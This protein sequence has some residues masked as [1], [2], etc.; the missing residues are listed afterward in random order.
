[1]TEY[2]ISLNELPAALLASSAEVASR[3]HH[4][5]RRTADRCRSHVIGVTNERIKDTTGVF[6]ASYEIDEA[7]NEI[8]LF[9][10]APHAEFVEE[11]TRPRSK[12][13]PLLPILLWLS[14]KQNAAATIA[15]TP[16]LKGVPASVKNSKRWD[17]KDQESFSTIGK[18][19]RA[20]ARASALE[21][22]RQHAVAI[23]RSIKEK[24]TKPHRIMASSQATFEAILTEELGGLD[25]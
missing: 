18:K 1:M 21:G 11:G 25:Q 13:V 22:L 2:T 6:A 8:T 9:N 24:G 7:P 3:V 23:A 4:V 14:R 16:V 5:L 19:G 10:S 20:A 12:G 15:G 17:L